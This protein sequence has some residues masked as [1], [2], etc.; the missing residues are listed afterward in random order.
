MSVISRRT[1]QDTEAFPWL[2]H[3]PHHHPQNLFILPN[4]YSVPTGHSLP[5]PHGL[6]PQP[7]V[8]FLCLW[9]RPLQGP[10]L[11]EV[12]QHPSFCAW[13]I[14]LSIA[15]S[16]VIHAAACVRVSFPFKAE[17]RPPMDRLHFVCPSAHPSMGTRVAHLGCCEHQCTSPWHLLSAAWGSSRSS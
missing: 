8:Y 5:S 2:C 15:S 1:A 12:R 13:I 14:S 3:L 9:M 7:P 16:G 11:G 10:P 6:S 4:R 17:Q